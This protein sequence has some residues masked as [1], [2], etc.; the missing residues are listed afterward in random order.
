MH[1]FKFVTKWLLWKD[2]ALVKER[3]CVKVRRKEIDHS[4]H[5]EMERGER[6]KDYG[7]KRI[8]IQF[9]ILVELRIQYTS[10][11]WIQLGRVY[12]YDELKTGIFLPDEKLYQQKLAVGS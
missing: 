8:F 10:V 12:K 7:W 3:D 5:L 4:S 9:D 1:N 6:V 11:H 2:L